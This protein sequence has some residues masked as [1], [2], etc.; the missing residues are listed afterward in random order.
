MKTGDLWGALAAMLVVVPSSIAFGVVIFSAVSP[1]LASAGALAGIIGAAMLGMIAP[2]VGRNAGFITSPCAPAAAVMA[3]LAAQLAHRGDL[4]IPRIFTL[5]A[6]TAF[7]AALFQLAL[8]AARAGQLI[9]YIPYQVVS[10]YLSGVAVI[11]AFA[12]L[13]KLL[14]VNGG[15][16][17]ADVLVSPLTWRWPGIVVGCI[18]I[19]AMIA[20]PHI[21]KR[22]P[23]AII[24]LVSGIAAYFA[25]A[26][27]L[28][29]LW[30]LDHNSLIVGPIRASGSLIAAIATRASS[31]RTIDV[32]DFE[33]VIWPAITL[34]IL[35][36]IDTL[37][38]GVVLDALTRRRH[39]SN[40]E[41][42][43]QGLANLGSF[44]AGGIPGAGGM[45]PTL[46]N[47]TSGGRT[48]WSGVATGVLVLIALL[49]LGSVIAW[50][51]IAALAGILLV[52]AWRMF[53]REMFRLLRDPATRLDFVV[54]VT[55]IAVAET[56]GLIQASIAGI[57][58]AI[59]LFIRNQI[60]GSVIARR[61]DL[62]EIHSKRRRSPDAM[63]ILD[64]RGE[65]A[66][67]VQLK[68]DLF[69]G[70]TDQLFIELEHDLNERRFILFDFRRVQSMDYTAAH[71][72][73]QMD[74]RLRERG[75]R[76][77][78]SGMPSG[79]ASRQ[80][81][82]HYLLKL[83]LVGGG[84]AVLTFD[85]RESALEWIED[86]ILESA[87]WS[88][89][90]PEATLSFRDIDLLRQFD[91]EIVHELGKSLRELAVARGERVFSAGDRG[92]E[93]FFVR[94]GRVHILLPLDGGKRHHVATIGRGEYFGEMAFL[95]R[96]VRS[97]EAVAATDTQ[98]YVISRALFDDVTQSNASLAATVF[99]QLA[100]AIAQ[101]LRHADVELRALEER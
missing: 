94:K 27:F 80:D 97:A 81:I 67:L 77:L 29:Q 26:T 33:L 95:D 62:R 61:L 35:L 54:I 28:P 24:G 96:D 68:D 31:L 13:P 90:D 30:R 72:L 92:D 99:E 1:N 22:I 101:R 57:C 8:G 65:D 41:L 55:V 89:G 3:G 76:L 20:A 14:G 59:L 86:R 44:F 56:V 63:A 74:A 6:L 75:G 47:V 79:T 84:D 71:L 16:S 18:T 45:G 69:F 46:V 93:I 42:I 23:G 19:I 9:K 70:T 48:I 73:R 2:L 10:G 87:G 53:D 83:G 11:I 64:R 50:V 60:R 17:L 88:A 51:P 34:A 36:S 37:K 82:E 49:L 98:L 32:A 38:T 25:L 39:N 40:R 15:R 21:T 43:A 5:L 78:F 58:L 52:I 100:R 91:D 7:I 85:T 4:T 12:Q 66:I